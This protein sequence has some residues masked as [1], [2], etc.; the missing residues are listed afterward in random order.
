V[1]EGPVEPRDEHR[2][3]AQEEEL[4]EA[5]E[6][7]H[8]GDYAP[9]VAARMAVLQRAGGIVMPVVT[10]LFAFAM[11]MIVIAVTGHNP[12]QAFRGSSTAPA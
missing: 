6:G 5:P 8:G 1:S 3:E 10:T 12:F 4:L 7:V 2:L 9:S 11:A